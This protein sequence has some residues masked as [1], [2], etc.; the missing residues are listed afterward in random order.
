MQ[1]ILA[2]VPTGLMLEA[3]RQCVAHKEQELAV[4]RSVYDFFDLLSPELE[5][6]LQ[7]LSPGVSAMSA[8]RRLMFVGSHRPQGLVSRVGALV[9]AGVKLH[10]LSI[11]L[12]SLISCAGSEGAKLEERDA[13]VASFRISQEAYVSA[14]HQ[15]HKEIGW[16]GLPAAEPD[17]AI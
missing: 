8:L 13:A 11:C 1:D 2:A 5:S 15:H 7:C 17:G 4:L 12:Q 14:P 9:R 6:Q 10:V 3:G 16:L